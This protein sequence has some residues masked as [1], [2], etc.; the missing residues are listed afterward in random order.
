MVH[1]RMSMS[2]ASQDFP[3]DPVSPGLKCLNDVPLSLKCLQS[4]VSELPVKGWM[5][6]STQILDLSQKDWKP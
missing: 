3:E 4:R 6:T 5:K 2:T 1:T